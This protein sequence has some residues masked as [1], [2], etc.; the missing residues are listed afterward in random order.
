MG[1]RL[2]DCSGRREPPERPGKPTIPTSDGRIGFGLRKAASG[3]LRGLG[4]LHQPVEIVVR[5]PQ[6][7]LVERGHDKVPRPLKPREC[8]IRTLVQ[9]LMKFSRV[10]CGSRP[11]RLLSPGL[12]RCGCLGSAVS[13]DRSAATPSQA[14]PRPVGLLGCLIS[15]P[16]AARPAGR[17]R[18]MRPDG[19]EGTSPNPSS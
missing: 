7:Q 9:H 16:G 2:Q 15:L 8:G 12:A 18:K 17:L 19:S 6:S 3:A 5:Q 10:R 13:R 14:L 4:G 1:H 11:T